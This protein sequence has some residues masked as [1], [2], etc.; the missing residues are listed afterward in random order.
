MTGIRGFC[1]GRQTRFPTMHE[2]LP[3]A[4]GNPLVIP[5]RYARLVLIAFC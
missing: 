4:E 2:D 5:N 1:S 3:K